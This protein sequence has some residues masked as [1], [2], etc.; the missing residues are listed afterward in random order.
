M[1]DIVIAAASV[2]SGAKSTTTMTI[3]IQTPGVTL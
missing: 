1:V 3:D 2:V